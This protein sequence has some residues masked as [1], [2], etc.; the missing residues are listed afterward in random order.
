M[1]V[2]AAYDWLELYLLDQEYPKA[3]I[4]EKWVSK[5][6]EKHARNNNWHFKE[7]MLL[8]V[9]DT[10]TNKSTIYLCEEDELELGDVFGIL[11]NA[12]N[13]VM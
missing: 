8:I 6:G 9:L 1:K 5:T 4:W 3:G 10:K 12:R 11:H 7:K 2:M 13:G